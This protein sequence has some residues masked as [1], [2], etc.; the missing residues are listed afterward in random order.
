MSDPV[1]KMFQVEIFFILFVMTI[2]LIGYGNFLGE[3]EDTPLGSGDKCLILTPEV[4][5][6][7]SHLWGIS[8]IWVPGPHPKRLSESRS[9]G[10]QLENV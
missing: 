5:W 9:Q 2:S 1:F 4:P 6:H 3:L 8:E 10:Q 7:P